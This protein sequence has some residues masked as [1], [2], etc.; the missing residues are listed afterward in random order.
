LALIETGALDRGGVDALAARLGLSARQL[1]RL[2]RQHLGATPNDVAQTRRLLLA[3]QLLQETGLSMTAVA[4]A[5]GYTSLRRFNETFQQLYGRAP[6]TIR[7]RG[8]APAG[9]EIALMLAYRPPYD[10]PALLSFLAARAIPGVEQ[11]ED[12]IY[13]RVI[14]LD[15]A[16]GTMA[17]AHV[18]E[19]AAL[20]VTLRL[21][22]LTQLPAII[23]RIRRLFDL[24]ADPRAIAEILG[25]DALL[26]PHI[27]ARPG[28]RVPG[29]WDGFEM[30]V[31]AVLGQ[32]ISVAAARSLA[33]HL[34]ALLGTPVDTGIAGLTHA[35]PGPEQFGPDLAPRLGMPRQRGATLHALAEAALA[36]PRLFD[37][38]PHLGAAVERLRR[39][40]G[41]GE[42]SAQYI[43]LRALAESDAFPASDLG[44]LRALA[45]DGVRPNAKTL[46]MRA[47]AWRPWRAYAAIH[48][49]M[50]ES[51]TGKETADAL[52]A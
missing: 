38:R 3:K 51:A 10:W 33:G 45:E 9:S 24:N 49:W 16:T 31:R 48:L 22:K 15:G 36:D 46:L 41:L 27:A 7:R 50:A 1:R 26:A 44:L 13:R 30:A 14:A 8:G 23:A 35:F 40:P 28:L 39:L 43:A 17:V 2:F 25:C 5:S 18:P 47:E 11:V 29:A 21:P 19:R 34:V 42:W 52:V 12:G 4:Q 6:S 37:I 20:R 32:Q